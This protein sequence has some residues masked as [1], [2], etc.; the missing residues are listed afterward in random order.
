MK[1]C[2]VGLFD[3]P[4]LKFTEEQ[5]SQELSDQLC[6]WAIAHKCG[7]RL[8]PTLWSFKNEKQRTLFVITHSE[9]FLG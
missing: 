6:E 7:T 5:M 3:L 2:T 4:G 9:K 1:E 8:T